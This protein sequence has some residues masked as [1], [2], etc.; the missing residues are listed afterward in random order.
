MSIT[1][2]IELKEGYL[3]TFPA[4]RFRIVKNAVGTL[5]A[6]PEDRSNVNEGND[7]QLHGAE[8]ANLDLFQRR[9]YKQESDPSPGPSGTR[10]D[11]LNALDALGRE[12]S[13]P[14]SA[15]SK[16]QLASQPAPAE[17]RFIGIPDVSRR[18]Q[19][20]VLVYRVPGEDLCYS[21]AL[22]R[23]NR[24]CQVYRCVSCKATANVYTKVTVLRN[25]EFQVDPCTIGHVC[26]PSRWTKE[27]T[28]RVLYDKYQDLRA[29]SSCADSSPRDEY[30]K[31]LMDVRQNEDITEEEKEE[32]LHFFR[33]Y[34][35]FRKTLKRNIKRSKVNET[36]QSST[37]SSAPDLS[38]A[39]PLEKKYRTGFGHTYAG[40]VILPA[41]RRKGEQERAM[42]IQR[43]QSLTSV[44]RAKREN[45]GNSSQV[46]KETEDAS[47]HSADNMEHSLP[48]TG[49]ASTP[50]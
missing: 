1:N 2:A 7:A 18:G 23:V 31:L 32:M 17:R 36:Q 48:F 49:R 42:R 43:G 8:N 30:H 34:E 29:D 15:F 41:L 3:I 25:V 33:N 26:L 38:E 22:H 12:R 44:L 40:R 35:R 45:E 9:L 11:R 16:A 37:D 24:S 6:V 39:S 14:T 47:V 4:G 27:K 28:K 10:H 50:S 21:F 19:H 20:P 5:L 46:S 13:A